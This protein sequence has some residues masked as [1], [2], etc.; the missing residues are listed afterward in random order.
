MLKK[1]FCIAVIVGLNNSVKS[2]EISS[3][4]TTT[5]VEFTSA[6]GYISG[7]YIANQDGWS[8]TSTWKS[9]QAIYNGANADR[10]AVKKQYQRSQKNQAL[11]ANIGEIITLQMVFKPKCI[12]AGCFDNIDAELFA[13]GL[14][15]VFDT[16]NTQAANANGELIAI[17]IDA[18]SQVGIRY[19]TDADTQDYT[20]NNWKTLT[21]KYFV[22]NSM[23]SSLIKAK[24]DHDSGNN[25]VSSGWVDQVWDS[26]SL[27]DAITTTGAYM[28][29]QSNTGLGTETTDKHVYIDSYTFHT[30]DPGQIFLGGGGI[31]AADTWSGGTA[32]SSIDRIY[33][34]NKTPNWNNGGADYA[35]EYIYVEWD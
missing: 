24:L 25:L 18:N 17:E 28:I 23:S 15:S 30:D 4:A 6:E 34:I 26:Q 20:V 32:P 14:K 9:A 1:I 16:S 33:I 12:D 7:N 31:A 8:G 19:K 10:I 21:I 29:F 27:Y 5:I 3:T 11:Q 35:Y 13:F 2:Q 22:G